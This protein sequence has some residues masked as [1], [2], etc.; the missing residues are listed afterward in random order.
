MNKSHHIRV[1]DPTSHSVSIPVIVYVAI[2]M[3]V[4]VFGNALVLIVYRCKIKKHSNYRLFVLMLATVDMTQSC[5]GMPGILVDMLRAYTFYSNTACKLLRLVSHVVLSASS[6]THMLI[7]IE[8]YCKICKPLKK[9]ISTK[10]AKILLWSVVIFSLMIG[11]PAFILYGKSRY[12]IG[13]T[14]ITISL[15]SYEKSY[16][17]TPYPA[18]YESSLF[19]LL[20][21]TVLALFLIYILIAR[22]IWK[23]K[24]AIHP[25][26]SQFG[27]KM[28]RNNENE[29]S[30]Q[31]L[32]TQT[33]D[34]SEVTS[35]LKGMEEIRVPIKRKATLQYVMKMRLPVNK[36]NTVIGEETDVGKAVHNDDETALSTETSK[37]IA[38]QGANKSENGSIKATAKSL[39]ERHEETADK[40]KIDQNEG[41]LSACHTDTK[42][43]FETQ[44]GK[45]IT[46]NGL[47]RNQTSCKTATE[48]LETQSK[49]VNTISETLESRT[50]QQNNPNQTL[51]TDSE[52]NILAQ[53]KT[54]K[55]KSVGKHSKK[56]TSVSFAITFVF[57][58]SY[59]PHFVLTILASVT[60]DHRLHL[61]AVTEALLRIGILSNIINNAAN[62]FIYY[63]M[64]NDFKMQC[65]SVFRRC[66]SRLSN[67]K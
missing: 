30:S 43:R 15:C 31:N 8:R 52:T 32:E 64:D 67:K 10:L 23:T 47:L 39:S 42:E 28:S 6:M 48:V 27:S 11:L 20:V 44:K 63:A 61:T 2:L 49:V 50:S 45:R 26:V 60:Q 54:T 56:V 13:H 55:F 3:V 40:I 4:G 16:L 12:I 66:C 22:Q 41:G 17:Q 57:I 65:K 37:A 34:L 14:N 33:E 18:I 9:Q 51:Q 5:I 59:V 35:K 24:R 38:G 21:S 58:I 46:T 19:T 62:P 29:A 53:K 7:G 25:F 36:I 1:P